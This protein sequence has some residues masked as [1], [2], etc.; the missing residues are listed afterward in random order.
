MPKA[1]EQIVALI[2][3]PYRDEIPKWEE[4]PKEPLQRVTLLRKSFPQDIVP[5]L[6]ELSELRHR[7]KAKFSRADAMFFDREALEQATSEEIARNRA[8][9]FHGLAGSIADLT[10]GNGGD[11]LALASQNDGSHFACDISEARVRITQSNFE[12]LCPD[13][14]PDVTFRVAPADDYPQADAYFIDPSRRS[15]GSRSRHLTNMSPSIDLILALAH[16]AKTLAVKLSP[17]TPDEELALLG[18]RVEFISHK[19]ECKEAVVW[20]GH[21]GP[22]SYRSANIN[23]AYRINVSPATPDPQKSES[24]AYILEPDPAIIRAGLIPELCHEIDAAVMDPQIAYLTSESPVDSPFVA[25]YEVL[26]S[27]PLSVKTIK[28]AL[29][30]LEIGQVDVKKRGVAQEVDDIRKQVKSDLPGRGV[31][32]LTRLGEKARAFIC[33]ALPR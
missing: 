2:D 19:G 23:G 5:V 20:Y 29:R 6:L 1:P 4:L 18:G 17:A 9:Q 21:A 24:L 32:I 28:G 25:T 3:S 8:G 15:M 10:C 7:A 27:L 13:M 12:A 11:M 26:A 30:E 14:L 22:S 16:R 31:V 33:R